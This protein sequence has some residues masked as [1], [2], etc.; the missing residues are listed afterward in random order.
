MPTQIE[1]NQTLASE[2]NMKVAKMLKLKEFLFAT[3]FFLFTMHYAKAGLG[4]HICGCGCGAYSSCEFITKV[5]SSLIAPTVDEDDGIV[6]MASTNGTFK[7]IHLDYNPIV[8]EKYANHSG[9]AIAIWSTSKGYIN[10]M[11][12]GGKSSSWISFCSNGVCQKSIS[13]KELQEAAVYSLGLSFSMLDSLNK[14]HDDDFFKKYV[15]LPYTKLSVLWTKGYNHPLFA[16]PIY[17]NGTLYVGFRD[18]FIYAIDAKNGDVKWSISNSTINGE[19][20]APPA[21]AK[22]LYVVTREGKLISIDIK[23]GKVNWQ[24]SIGSDL[25]S[26]P[27]ISKDAIYIASSDGTLYAFDASGNIK[28]KLSLDGH[29]CA[30]PAIDSKG[31]LYIGT[32]KGKFYSISKNGSINWTY[33][34]GSKIFSY[35]IID[36][37]GNIYFYAENHKIFKLNREGLV[38]DKINVNGIGGRKYCLFMAVDKDG[39]I[40]L[41]CLIGGIWIYDEKAGYIHLSQSYRNFK[42]G[43]GYEMYS[44]FTID[45][46]GILYFNSPDLSAMGLIKSNITNALSD[47]WSIFYHD[48]S[49]RNSNGIP[50]GKPPQGK[51]LLWI[52][53]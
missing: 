47:S 39:T 42:T 23:K 29:V 7:A 49:H 34:A 44:I 8:D 45:K 3:V 37:M 30:S 35:P 28:W 4:P 26:P 40:M 46:N 32:S 2:E 14:W 48:S 19:I 38:L 36:E 53:K 1:G 50:T 11:L 17:A 31:N 33:S 25:Y 51:L 12:G 27:S 52:E 16:S 41:S 43:F 5:T 15:P 10:E 20:I 6:Y 24:K 18:G 13:K 22:D 21:L 9:S